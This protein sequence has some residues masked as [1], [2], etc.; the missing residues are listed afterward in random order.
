MLLAAS[1]LIGVVVALIRGGSIRSFTQIELR[2]PLLIFA[3]L[4][5]KVLIFSAPWKESVGSEDVI[6]RASYILSMALVLAGIYFN[7]QIPGMKLMGLGVL[8]NF[9]V[10]A[11]N[12][13]YMPLS[14]EGAERLQV[15]LLPGTE[16]LTDPQSQAVVMSQSTR[17]RLLGDIFPLPDVL[18]GG[19]TSLGDIVLC[20][21]AFYGAQCIMLREGL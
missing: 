15:S 2:Y 4:G 21:G 9:L 13:G 16:V 10:I 14:P 1:L 18:T 17:L 6:S 12:G 7:H 19:M 5:L 3:G 20:V 8:L 11:A